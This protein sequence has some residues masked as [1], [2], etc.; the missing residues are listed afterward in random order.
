MTYMVKEIFRTLQGEGANVGRPAVFIRFS[1][2]NLWSG[3]ER[4]RAEAVCKFCDTEF[5]GGDRIKNA[6]DLADMA[7]RIW[8]G[9]PQ[10]RFVVLTGGEPALQ[11]DRSLLDALRSRHFFTAIETN[12]T[13]PLK[14]SPDWIT[15]SPKTRELK[16]MDGD[17]LKLIYPQED[18]S[19]GDFEHLKF[20]RFYLQPKWERWS[21]RRKRNLGDAMRLCDVHRQWRLSIQM[22]K[23]VGIA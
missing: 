22:H 16:V 13:I 23:V 4:D 10:N 6:D 19:P 2:C 15:V 7:E 17:E 3:R 1:G 18:V 8:D 11:V 14:A 9:G 5:V 12:G 20:G 21:W